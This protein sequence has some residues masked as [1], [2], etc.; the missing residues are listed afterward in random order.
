MI[1]GLFGTWID[2][3]SIPATLRKDLILDLKKHG[4]KQKF[5][6]Y[7][8]AEVAAISVDLDGTIRWY[9][10]EST[11]WG[12]SEVTYSLARLMLDQV[13][14]LTPMK[15]DEYC[16]CRMTLDGIIHEEDCKNW[17]NYREQSVWGIK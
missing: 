6:I 17:V 1:E 12:I 7:D 15:A 5:L 13:E 3:K 2:L 16:N 9:G 8:Y 11:P 4:H 10:W 14:K